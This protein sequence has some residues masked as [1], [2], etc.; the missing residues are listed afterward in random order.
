VVWKWFGSG[1]EVVRKLRV[2]FNR[3][4]YISRG[5]IK[6]LRILKKRR[7]SEENLLDSKW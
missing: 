5:P 4:E 7:K 1:L 3:D 2:V 6:F